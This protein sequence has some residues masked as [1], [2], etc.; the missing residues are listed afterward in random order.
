[1][2]KRVICVLKQIGFAASFFA[3]VPPFL[4]WLYHKGQWIAATLM[5]E[6]IGSLALLCALALAIALIWIIVRI[7]PIL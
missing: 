5:T 4:V 2:F 7:R 3:D 1:M 6:P